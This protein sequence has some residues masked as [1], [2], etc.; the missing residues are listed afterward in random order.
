MFYICLIYNNYVVHKLN[1]KMSSRTI[2]TNSINSIKL[3]TRKNSDST[4]KK[5]TNKKDTNKK[6]NYNKYHKYISTISNNFVKSQNSLLTNLFHIKNNTSFTISFNEINLDTD[7]NTSAYNIPKFIDIFRYLL[8][9]NE[10]INSFTVNEQTILKDKLS[11]N[12]TSKESYKF[13]NSNSPLPKKILSVYNSITSNTAILNN[14]HT[15]FP[16]L[17]FH[18]LLINS[19]TSYKILED[20]ELNIKKVIIFSV[21]W[22]DIKLDN[23]LYL[24]M[25]EN[26]KHNNLSGSEQI[27][28]IGTEI[29]K[30]ILFFNE[31]LDIKTHPDKFIIFFTNNKKEIDKELITHIHFKTINVNSAVTNGRDIIIYREQELLKSIFHESIHFY[32]LDFRTIPESIIKYLIQTHNIDE[33]NEYLL[34]ECVTETLANILNNIYYSGTINEFTINLVNEI[35]FSTLQVSKILKICKYKQWSDF[36]KISTSLSSSVSGTSHPDRKKNQHNKFKQDSCVFSYYILKLYIMINLDEYFKTNLDNKLKF[37]Q[38]EQSFNNLIKI[39]DASRNN[40]QLI[41][42]I[43]S[44]LKGLNKKNKTKTKNKSSNK[45]HNTLRMTCLESS[46]VGKNSI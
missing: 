10:F 31:F 44:I 2:C 36:S 1:L 21:Q 3:L 13:L 9:I 30:R 32:N 42:I 12:K 28:T 37:I 26:N 43:N 6:D 38:T 5:D 17:T 11:S 15:K 41:N 24:F 27:K 34:Y 39:F 7:T 23:F 33:H 29:I 35:M 8:S 20:L 40:L 45:I 19:F 16:S 14:L 22:K 25:Y 18:N 4:N 46:F